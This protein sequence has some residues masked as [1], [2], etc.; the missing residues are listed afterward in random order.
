MIPVYH[1]G[2]PYADL[3]GNLISLPTLPAGYSCVAVPASGDLTG[4]YGLD[5][6]GTTGFFVAV[7]SSPY[8]LPE[9]P[10]L[11]NPNYGNVFYYWQ[12]RFENFA[13]QTTSLDVYGGTNT[14]TYGYPLGQGYAQGTITSGLIQIYS[15]LVDIAVYGCASVPAFECWHTVRR[16]SS[17]DI[18][19]HPNLLVTLYNPAHFAYPGEHFSPR[20]ITAQFGATIDLHFVQPFNQYSPDSVNTTK[21]LSVPTLFYYI[22]QSLSGLVGTP[23]SLP[24][25]KTAA[26]GVELR[27][28]RTGFYLAAPLNGLQIHKFATAFQ[29][30][31][32]L[33]TVDND[34]SAN[35]PTLDALTDGEGLVCF[36]RKGTG[37]TN[38]PYGY[39]K[40][41]SFDGAT[42][43]TT[44]TDAN[45]KEIAMLTG[46]KWAR[47][48]VLG[49][50]KR[51]RGEAVIYNDGS[52]KDS[53]G[54]ADGTG[55][56]QVNLY[57]AGGKFVGA[58]PVDGKGIAG[59]K[60]D[61]AGFGVEYVNDANHDIRVCFFSGGSLVY[62]VS[63]EDGKSWLD[64]TSQMK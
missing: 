37:N 47:I 35:Y 36:Y 48:V 52:G 29:K 50:G 1:I 55:L 64:I 16:N 46:K 32:G 41:T 40:R 59:K 10:P 20:T 9:Y 11:P 33:L 27:N 28:T 25:G 12:L 43:W 53:K 45:G 58:F 38:S 19:Q 8:L 22:Y 63:V 21:T 23:P 56:M 49:D 62:A 17:D 26:Q 7:P 13:Y 57:D 51:A 42:T 30:Y 6:V 24:P 4:L 5:T 60:A 15:T 44:Q 3:N 31:L 34:T 2:Y 39:V 14:Q 54:L 61:D 18:N